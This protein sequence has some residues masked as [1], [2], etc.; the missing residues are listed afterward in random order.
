MLSNSAQKSP[1]KNALV[2]ILQLQSPI[3]NPPLNGALGT[4]TTQKISHS[5]LKPIKSLNILSEC[6]LTMHEKLGWRNIRRVDAPPSKEK[7]A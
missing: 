4:Q 7:S 5:N 3:T 1:W 6:F 2:G